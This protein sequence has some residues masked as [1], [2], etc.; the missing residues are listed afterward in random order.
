MK[1]MKQGARFNNH[2]APV[3]VTWSEPVNEIEINSS[4]FGKCMC[5]TCSGLVSNGELH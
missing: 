1:K 5:V 2:Q 3:Q 4:D